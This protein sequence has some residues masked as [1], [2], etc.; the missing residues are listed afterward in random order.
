M[1][2]TI[3]VLRLRQEI[4]DR[5]IKHVKPNGSVWCDGGL[6]SIRYEMIGE[7]EMIS[8]KQAA[9]LVGMEME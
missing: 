8:W 2:D 4:L 6:P 1:T 5:L 3:S 7:P 9:E